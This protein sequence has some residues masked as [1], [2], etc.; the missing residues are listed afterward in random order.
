MLREI[1]ARI[2]QG[3]RTASYPR[4]QPVLPP[5][6]RGRPSIKQASCPQGCSDCEQDCPT[7]AVTREDNGPQIDMGKCLFC[8]QC[9]E[10][11]PEQAIG[12]TSDYRLAAARR[13]DLWVNSKQ[14]KEMAAALNDTAQRLFKRSFRLRQVSAGGCNACEADANVLGTLLYDMGRFGIEFVASP[15]HAD[16]LLVT[17]PV[18]RNMELGLKKTWNA[19]PEP[20]L[21]IAAGACA[22]NGGPFAGNP[23]VAGSTEAL[24]PVDLYV[25][26]CPPH[27]YTLLDGM[28]RMLGRL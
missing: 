11:C 2:G 13:A 19:M 24:I 22:I 5:R 7:Q 4:V 23:Q 18:T 27:P 17:G 1:V 8:G 15:R 3:H 26:G 12:F 14:G 28:L 20:R 9:A 16:A 6:F 10:L 21:V 25:P